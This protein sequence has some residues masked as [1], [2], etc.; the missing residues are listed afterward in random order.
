ME[1]IDQLKVHYQW[2]LE[3]ED[4]LKRLQEFGKKYQEAFIEELY[5]YLSNFEDTN[6][7][8]PNEQVMGR[9]KEKLKDWF[10]SLFS[11]KYDTVYLR[12]LYRISEVHVKLGLPPHNVI[13]SMNF[14]RQFIERKLDVELLGSREKGSLMQAVNKILDINLD[15]LT[16]SYRE[17]ELKLYLA[18]G[19]YQK[20]LIEN[21]RKTSWFFD[22]FIIVALALVGLF[23]IVGIGENILHAVRGDLPLDRGAIHVMGSLVI[24]YAV[25]ELLNEGIRHVRG[26][27]LGLRVFIMVGLAAV[28]RKVLIVSLSPPEQTQELLILALLLLSLGLTY[29][30]IRRADD[31]T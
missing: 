20:I 18:S 23:L 28:I 25:S 21:V 15:I 9:H 24:L 7:Y 16:S 1:T 19:K 3:V 12:R 10:V 13:A 26:A 8:L 5:A 31:K 11:G 30:L 2:N 4:H 14:V 6:M 29:W 27:S 22:V 17:E